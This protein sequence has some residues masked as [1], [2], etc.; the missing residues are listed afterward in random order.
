MGGGHHEKL[1]VPHYS[2]YNNYRKFPELA[3][4][5]DKLKRL[6]LRDPWIR[7]HVH[8]FVNKRGMAHTFWDVTLR[9]FRPGLIAAATVI[10]IEEGYSFLKYGHT[11]WGAHH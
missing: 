4:H 8:L 3:A 2:V 10:A 11:S 1:D 9:G 5:E 7:N 6:G